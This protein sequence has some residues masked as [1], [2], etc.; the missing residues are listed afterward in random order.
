MSRLQEYHNQMQ[1]QQA[2]RG[3]WK[4][5]RWC[6][7]IQEVEIARWS[8]SRTIDTTE[9]YRLHVTRDECN[10]KIIQGRRAIYI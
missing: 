6:G 10:H 3:P 4:T 8:G 1:A 2:S 5:C 7:T 9:Q